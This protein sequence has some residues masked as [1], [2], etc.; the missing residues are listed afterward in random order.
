MSACWP[1]L[2]GQCP[3]GDIGCRSVE[4]EGVC[5]SIASTLPMIF[6]IG[7]GVMRDLNSSFKLCCQPQRAMFSGYGND[8]GRITL[9]LIL[10][11]HERRRQRPEADALVFTVSESRIDRTARRRIAAARGGN[12][13]RRH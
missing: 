12:G 2:L 13:G 4:P 3:I 9:T 11:R 5:T 6:Q 8:A 10:F 7:G 1:T